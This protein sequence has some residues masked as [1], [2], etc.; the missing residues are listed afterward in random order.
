[1]ERKI[2]KKKIEMETNAI[3]RR[4]QRALLTFF[5]SQDHFV[6]NSVYKKLKNMYSPKSFELIESI[7]NEVP[8]SL[9]HDMNWDVC[10]F[11][12]LK[13]QSLVN[14]CLKKIIFENELDIFVLDKFLCLETNFIN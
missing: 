2:F 5:T 3:T 12:I 11:K 1:M 6:F 13:K 10:I 8:Y 4:R 9:M 7:V 14:L